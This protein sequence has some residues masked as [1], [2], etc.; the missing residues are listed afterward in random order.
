M[1]GQASFPRV[2]QIHLFYKLQAKSLLNTNFV[3]IHKATNIVL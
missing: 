2:N 3:F 1:K